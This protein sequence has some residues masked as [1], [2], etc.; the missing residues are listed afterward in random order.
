[1]VCGKQST[2]GETGR[3]RFGDT[4]VDDFGLRLII[5]FGDQNVRRFFVTMD[6]AFLVGMVHRSADRGEQLEAFVLIEPPSITVVGDRLSRHHLHDEVGS[7]GAGAASVED[8]GD[9][10]VVHQSERL[11]FGREASHH[12]FGLEPE[13]DD[14][15]R[16]PAANRLPLF[17]LPDSAESTFAEHP[18]QFF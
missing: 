7:S 13:L 12:P 9:A 10:G 3:N 11:A 8:L 5:S 6:D 1:M 16:H 18:E 4:K 17:G 2:V 15:E 14:L